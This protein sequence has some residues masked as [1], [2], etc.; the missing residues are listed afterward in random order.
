MLPSRTPQLQH[1]RKPV[2]ENNP[3]S[4]FLLQ[5]DWSSH[6]SHSLLRFPPQGIE[7]L[8]YDDPIAV[9]AVIP[10]TW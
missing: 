6:S 1:L 10:A 7:T 2:V 8:N 3:V 5:Y 4:L 9:A